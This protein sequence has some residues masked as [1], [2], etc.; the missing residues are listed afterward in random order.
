MICWLGTLVQASCS[1]DILRCIGHGRHHTIEENQRVFG[2]RRGWTLGRRLRSADSYGLL[3]VLI[4][5]SLFATTWSDS[6]VGELVAIVLQGGTLVFALHTSRAKPFVIRMAAALVIVGACLALLSWSSS[7]AVRLGIGSF[8]RLVLSLAAMTAILRRVT[9]HAEADGKTLLGALCIYLLLGNLFAT[10]YGLIGALQKGP[11][12]VGL[13][14]GS[15]SDRLYFSFTTMTTL[16]YGDL[17]PSGDVGRM[18][19][20]TEALL[21]QLYLVSVVALIVGNL[22]RGR[23]PRDRLDG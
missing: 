12:F 22:G 5:S 2:V 14:D 23:P 9:K 20:I 6:T 16:G 21:G 7:E 4:I 19:A 10:G 18:L 8:V 11:F 15:W 13:N 3:L 1:N 17:T